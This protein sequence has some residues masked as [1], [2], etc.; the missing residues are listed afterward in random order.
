MLSYW[1]VRGNANALSSQFVDNQ[2]GFYGR[3]LQG[4]KEMKPR[5][6]RI[7]Q[8]VNNQ[9]G[10]ALGQL[11]V[12]KY[13]PPEAKKRMNT[14]VDNL[15]A[16][17][18][19]RILHTVW[20]DDS[21]KE[22]AL[23]KLHAIT[24]KIGYPDKW[25]NYEGVVINTDTYLANMINTRKYA[26][27]KM[28][29]KLDKPVDPTEWRMTPPTVNAYYQPNNNEIVF[30]AGILQPP[31]F[32][33]DADDAVNYGAIGLVIAH[34]I[35]HGF[36]DKGRMYDSKGNLN[37]WWTKED[38]ERYNK[39]ASKI[40]EQFNNYTVLDGIH[41]NG[42]LTQGE[43]I[44]DLGGMLIAYD[45]FKRTKE[46]QSDKLIDGLTPDQRFFLSYA[47]VWQIKNTD[48]SIRQNVLTDPHSPPQYRVNG[49]LSNMPAFYKAFNVKP[50][51]Q[52]Y[53]PDSM[54]V[55]IW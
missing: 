25:D 13:F 37:D 22:K 49:P 54:H 18:E 34:E 52:L 20:M 8:V 32:D 39:Q 15:L 10:D 46:G 17:Y 4:Q 41:L 11:Y 30:P 16:A 33:K 6:K 42:E 3:T 29:A 2:F 47:K 40:I 43:N 23:E 21:T 26:Y 44:A 28:I 51:D 31:F 24:R 50:G 14:L 19:E 36:D 5:W 1:I 45:A 7:S 48:E 38:A 53:R 12:A 35:T 55:Q 9:L 27:N